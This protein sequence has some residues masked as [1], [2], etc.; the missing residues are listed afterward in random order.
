MKKIFGL[1]I[2]ALMVM[3]LVVGGT[4]AY[5]TD[6]ETSAD[7]YLTAGTLDL[8]IDGDNEAVYTFQVAAAGPGD[9]GTGT[10]LLANVGSY[11]GEL[12][13]AFSAVANTPGSGGTE[14]EGGSGELGGVATIAV[15]IDKNRNGSFDTGDIG[16]KHDGTTYTPSTPDYATIDSY[17]SQSWNA[18]TV[19]VNTDSDDFVV[20][21]EIPTDAGNEIQGDSVEFDVTFTLEQE[22]AD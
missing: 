15:F 4:L 13:I 1:T 20:E 6:E 10:S 2:A 16:L 18:V 8:N 11:D 19:I 21:W 14:Y 12:D 5:F 9:S 22:A 3:A 17:D 7:N